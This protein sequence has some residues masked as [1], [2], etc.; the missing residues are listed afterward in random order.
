MFDFKEVK[1]ASTQERI[2]AWAIERAISVRGLDG[3]S[4]II[5]TAHQIETYIREGKKEENA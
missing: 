1:T 3:D 4:E 2:R 5:E